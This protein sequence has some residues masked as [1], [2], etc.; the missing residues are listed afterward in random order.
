MAT[1]AEIA[2]N[3]LN[4]REST[5]PRTPEGR[6]KSSMNAL[7]HG[8]RS[9]KLALLGEQSCAFEERLRKSMA[10]GDAQNDVE[11]YLTEDSQRNRYRKAVHER[12]PD[13]FRTREKEEW[14]QILF[15]L[16]QIPAHFR[17]LTTG[18]PSLRNTACRN[19]EKPQNRDLKAAIPKLR[20]WPLVVP[21]RV[22]R[23]R[24][25]LS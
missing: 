18:R 21:A 1:P 13:L 14:Q 24:A 2:A 4:S 10:I 17:D 20:L 6:A 5:G 11:E 19:T 25:G 12:W 22:W 8:N 9:R 7:K 15:E 16:R 3:Q 23:A